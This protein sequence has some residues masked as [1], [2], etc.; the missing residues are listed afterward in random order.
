MYR[1]SFR[2]TFQNEDA[3]YYQFHVFP[4]V[5]FLP[6]VTGWARKRDGQTQVILVE[7]ADANGRDRFLELLCENPHVSKIEEIS[8][9]EFTYAPSH[10]I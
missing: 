9:E 5:P 2:I 7:L 4:P 8:E 10:E 3:A 1:H 6:W